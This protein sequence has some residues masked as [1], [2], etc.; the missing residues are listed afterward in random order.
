[1]KHLISALCSVIIA[2]LPAIAQVS[3]TVVVIKKPHR[4]VIAERGDSGMCLEVACA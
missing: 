3:D 2:V 1:M 4:I